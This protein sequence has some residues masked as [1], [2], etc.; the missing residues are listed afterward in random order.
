MFV[1]DDFDC[2]AIDIEDFKKALDP[3]TN[4]TMSRRYKNVLFTG[5]TIFICT[6]KPINKWFILDED[7]SREAVFR[8]INYVI[9]FENN[10][11]TEEL[12]LED[13]EK[14]KKVEGVS[15]YTV[16]KIVLSDKYKDIYGKFDRVVS[17]YREVELEPINNEIKEFDLRKYV[18]IHADENKEQ[19]FLKQIAEI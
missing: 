15:R 11:K 1:Y 12:T 4:T 16:N 2:D 13:S 3:H 19:N 8:R 14:P 10:N 7:S 18:D 5:D 6:N 9:D 17:R